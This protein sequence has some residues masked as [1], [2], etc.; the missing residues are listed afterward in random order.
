MET[1]E[2]EKI[3]TLDSE[4]QGIVDVYNQAIKVC[5]AFKATKTVVTRVE[6]VSAE[7]QLAI[8]L[9]NL[10]NLFTWKS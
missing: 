5:E 9:E 4:T 10:S 7:K 1:L 3:E 8:E 6:Q 2:T